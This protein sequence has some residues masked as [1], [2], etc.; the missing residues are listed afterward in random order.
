MAPSFLT[1]P[2]NGHLMTTKEDNDRSDNCL[3][4]LL[5]EEAML[6]ASETISRAAK[7]LVDLNRI[8]LGEHWDKLKPS[9]LDSYSSTIQ[10]VTL[11]ITP[12]AS[13]GLQVW[14]A[15]EPIICSV[16][17]TISEKSFYGIAKSKFRKAADED[18]TILK[19]NKID[20][21]NFDLDIRGI[22]FALQY[23]PAALVDKSNLL[24]TLAQEPAGSVDYLA[25]KRAKMYCDTLHISDTRSNARISQ[26]SYYA[27][28]L[29]AKLCGIYSERFGFL[30]ES[31]LLSMV[32]R[33]YH[34]VPQTTSE[35][36]VKEFFSFYSA[37]RFETDKASNSSRSRWNAHPNIAEP[38]NA[39]EDDPATK[40]L[41][42]TELALLGT[43][44]AIVK[45]CLKVGQDILSSGTWK[46]SQLIYGRSSE[47]ESGIVKFLKQ[48]KE[49]IKIDVSCW[50]PSHAK[51]GRFIDWIDTQ[52]ADTVSHLTSSALKLRAWPARL[53]SHR[54]DTEENFYEAF[55]LVGVQGTV[56][57][58]RLL[59][60]ANRIRCD[61]Q[62]D[63]RT[64]FADI[65][66]VSCLSIDDTVL[67][68]KYWGLIADPELPDSSDDEDDVL[69]ENFSTLLKKKSKLKGK[70][71]EAGSKKPILAPQLSTPALRPALDILNR[72]LHDPEMDSEDYI[73][74]YLDRIAGIKEMPVSWWKAED[75]TAE[76]F[77]PQSR[78]RYFKRKSDGVIV[79]EREGR[80]DLVF[81]SGLSG[82]EAE[83]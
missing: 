32:A 76:D 16:A 80:V 2:S 59:D 63:T 38:V 51:N 30:R 45:E 19:S 25:K 78:I 41:P 60:F 26:L 17:G 39:L 79:W 62:Y 31:Q 68:D 13:Y 50:A 44:G 43:N 28:K 66:L 64:S 23:Y 20:T 73:V 71:K 48:Y 10:S 35:A 21:I 46:W 69:I 65:S 27:I 83:G 14:E 49:Y 34:R 8:L 54:K 3:R 29:W 77:I 36:V 72:I 1:M 6:P 55:Y 56:P 52:V 67:D 11:I 53:K 82:V 37:L 5:V 12:I 58:N 15:S 9:C 7:A 81:K 24:D 70:A 75:S 4:S 40:D 57:S 33:S 61:P 42:R 47:H 18:L 22:R 74:G